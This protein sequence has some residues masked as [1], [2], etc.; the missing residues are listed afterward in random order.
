MTSDSHLTP[1]R[2]AHAMFVTALS[3][4]LFAA[5]TAMFAALLTVAPAA[6]LYAD[7]I[8]KK[9][10]IAEFGE[11]LYAAGLEHFPYANPDAPKGGKIV[12]SDFGS[13]D[14]LNFYV[15]KGDW[16]SSIGVVYD[17]LMTSSADEIDGLYGLIAESVEYPADK[18]WAIFNLRD[19]A[20]YHDGAP[21]VAADFVHALDTVKRHG[22]VFVQSVYE[23]VTGAEALSDKRLKFT[24]ATTDS[25]KPITTAAGMSPLPVHYWK[26]KDVTASTL[27]P[28]LSSGPYRIADIDPGRSITYQRVEDYWARDLPIKRGLNNIDEIRY[29]YYRDLTVEF[30]AFKAGELDFRTENSAKRWATE[31][32]LPEITAGAIQKHTVPN[33]SPRGMGGYFFN[34]KRD[35][36]QDIRVR[37]ALMILYDF[38]AIQRTLL[39]GQYKRIASYFPNSDYGA[40]GEPDAAEKTLLSAFA[41]QTEYLPAAALS[42]AFAPPVTDGSGRDR[43]QRRRALGLFKAAGWELQDRKLVSAA[44]G[45]QFQL[46]LMTGY[47]ES[48]RLALPYI[49]ALK[50][51][52]IDASI[53]LVDPSQWRVRINDYDFDL[54]VG[55]LNFFPPPGAELRGFFGS[56]SADLR[57][58]N[59]SG[60]KNPVVDALI[61]QIVDAKQ[62]QTLQTATRALDRVLLWNHYAIPTYYKDEAW[63]AYWNRFGHPARRPVYSVGFPGAWWIDADKDARLER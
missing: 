46:E 3:A 57:G 16:P 48:Q 51:T 33:R 37:E 42:D 52:G 14:T 53:R 26:G 1:R 59:Y 17:S 23:Q 43:R 54:W 18:S 58:G 40:R 41:G 10:A 63:I 60:I 20:V 44:T 22:R 6:K 24:F 12:V 19:E 29:E 50:K 35:K 9:W 13:F 4:L 30:E 31:Y 28:P 15:Q 62:S 27:E 47:P 2:A 56:A 38:E 39:Y 34:L 8:T 49:E 11:P 61:E 45:A 7:G 36:F 55:G 32:D 21:I 5:V 25:M